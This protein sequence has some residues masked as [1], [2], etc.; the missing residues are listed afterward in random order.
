MSKPPR[1]VRVL[2]RDG[3]L[4]DAYRDFFARYTEDLSQNFQR[5]LIWRQLRSLRWINP[6]LAAR[7]LAEV[8]SERLLGK[9]T[10]LDLSRRHANGD[11]PGL[12]I[13]TTLYN[14]GRRLAGTTLPPAS[15]HYDFT[16]DLEQALEAEGRP[17]AIP[18]SLK[19]RGE[20]LLPLTPVDLGMDLCVSLLAGW[21]T[22]SAAFPPLIGPLSFRV[23]GQEIY[24]HTGDGG[25]YENQGV[26]SLLFLFL[27]QL[28]DRRIRRALLISFDS[29]FPFSVG[30]RR[31]NRRARPFTLR[32][33]DFSRVPSIMEER[34][35]TYQRL[36]FNSLRLE[37]VVPPDDVLRL[38]HLR[39]G[40]A[41]WQPD[42]ADLPAACRDQKPPLQ[43]P[44]AVAQ[45][46]EEIPT[47]LYVESE[48]DRQLLA[49]AAAKLVAHHRARILELLDGEQTADATR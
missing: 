33:F 8:L 36:F 18:T 24:W 16:R 25:L 21:V 35:T 29:S 11:S 34:A 42:L 4:T 9:A 37:G 20:L 49:V 27:K 41:E 14:N 30:D 12:I 7:S 22:A 13:N 48:C 45:R 6:A 3:A 5:A 1:S 32:T 2:T 31:L 15:F 40:D 44:A 23:A 26:E 17:S 47:L 46:I 43:T 39:H 10:V 38:I 28:Q 19:E